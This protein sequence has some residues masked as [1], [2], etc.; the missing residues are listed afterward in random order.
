MR[1]YSLMHLNLPPRIK[2]LEALGSIADGRVRIISEFEAE[3]MSSTGDRKYKVKVDMNL[4]KVFSDDNGTLYRNYIG[5]PI[6]AFLMLKGI[7]P[8]DRNLAAAL[9]GINWR[10]LNEMYKNYS[11]VEKYV[12]NLLRNKGFNEEYIDKF[13]N[14]VLTALRTL[15]LERMLSDKI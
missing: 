13:I 1:L 5:Y 15:S 11:L 9:K 3:V 7:I 4:R 10:R 14:D 2:V 8:Y 12:K 6:I